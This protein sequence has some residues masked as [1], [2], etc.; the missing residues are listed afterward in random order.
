MI[1]SVFTI[2]CMCVILATGCGGPKY[3]PDITLPQT[4]PIIDVIAEFHSL[5]P[6]YALLSGK[7]VFGLVA[8]KAEWIEPRELIRQVESELLKE[9]DAVG[10]FSRVTR[11]HPHPDVVL[12]GRIM[13][14]HED[15]RPQLWTQI[16]HMVPY[17]DMI[18]Q[19]LRLK[20]HTS[21]GEAHLILF[22][23]KPTGELIGTYIGKSTFKEAFNPTIDVP[24][25]ARLNRALSD[26]VRQIQDAILRDKTLRTFASHSR[27]SNDILIMG[28]NAL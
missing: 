2:S 27:Q 19:L 15:Y 24:P 3:V 10:M 14:L 8:P 26:A 9:L 22:V 23:L 25:G 21:S 18:A 5:Y 4:G 6:T 12:T 17:A 7:D 11:F 16:P 20:T 13:A 1:R 28:G